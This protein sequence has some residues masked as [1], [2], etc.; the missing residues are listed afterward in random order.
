VLPRTAIAMAAI[1][2]D[3]YVC[4]FLDLLFLVS[5]S[6]SFLGDKALSDEAG[7]PADVLDG[8][9][10]LSIDVSRAAWFVAH[11]LDTKGSN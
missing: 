4:Y 7:S 10:C 9:R 5:L 2:L 8:P 1:S 11:L 3:G 6:S